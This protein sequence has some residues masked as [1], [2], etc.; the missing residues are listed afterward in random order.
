ME[1]VRTLYLKIFRNTTICLVRPIIVLF[2]PIA[3]IA[4]FSLSRPKLTFIITASIPYTIRKKYKK[5]RIFTPLFTAL[6]NAVDNE[7]VL[8]LAAVGLFH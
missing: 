7:L 5:K 2:I 4:P 1:K 6:N 8:S 3:N